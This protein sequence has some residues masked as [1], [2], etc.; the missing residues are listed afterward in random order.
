M[1]HVILELP[2]KFQ[3]LFVVQESETQQFSLFYFFAQATDASCCHNCWFYCV[4]VTRFLIHFLLGPCHLLSSKVAD[5]VI[6]CKRRRETTLR[7]RK[8]PNNIQFHVQHDIEDTPLSFGMSW[9][10]V[11]GVVPFIGLTK[12]DKELQGVWNK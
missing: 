9:E 2:K 11:I 3:I 7:K 10:L 5:P 4:C 8:P 6:M 1:L 12:G